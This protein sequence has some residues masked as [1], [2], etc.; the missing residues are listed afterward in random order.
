MTFADTLASIALDQQ[1]SMTATAILTLVATFKTLSTLAKE[2]RAAGRSIK[3]SI[4]EA[5]GAWSV[6]ATAPCCAMAA[7]WTLANPKIIVVTETSWGKPHENVE[8]PFDYERSADVAVMVGD[9][10]VNEFKKLSLG[11]K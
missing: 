11:F 7:V 4:G 5:D 10:I 9:H 6:R 8:V 3:L 1:E 2:Y